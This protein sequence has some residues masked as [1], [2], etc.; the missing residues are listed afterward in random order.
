[1]GI[2][3]K[4]MSWIVALAF[5]LSLSWCSYQRITDPEPAARRALEESVVAAARETLVGYLGTEPEFVDP[6]SPDRKVGKVFIFPDEQGW[7]VS[8]Y[9]R[10]P[11]E[12]RWNPFLMSLDDQKRMLSLSVRDLDPALAAR[13]ADDPRLTVTSLRP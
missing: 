13:A 10:R 4:I 12:A 9:Y 11:G 5:G 8:G 2:N 6:L 1:M 7:Q 3:H